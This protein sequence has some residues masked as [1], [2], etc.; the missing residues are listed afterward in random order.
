[1]IDHERVKALPPGGKKYREIAEEMGVSMPSVAW[2]LR[3]GKKR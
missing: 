1:L 3:E 2:I